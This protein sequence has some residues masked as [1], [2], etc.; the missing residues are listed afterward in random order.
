[1]FKTSSS[2]SNE[3]N[4]II[5][6]RSSSSKLWGA[7]VTQHSMKYCLTAVKCEE[8]NATVCLLSWKTRTQ[9][10]FYCQAQARLRHSGSFRHSD[11][12][13]LTV[14]RAWADT[15]ILEATTTHPPTH[16]PTFKHEGGVPQKNPKS[17]TDLEWSPQPI[18]HKNFRWTMTGST[19][20]SPT[21]SRRTSSRGPTQKPKE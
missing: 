2:S 14:T 1:M 17:K 16:P 21:C 8:A 6:L 10:I 3:Y 5:A 11:S 19:W 15:K 4:S 13:S 7:A 18:H 9:W 20:G 12:G